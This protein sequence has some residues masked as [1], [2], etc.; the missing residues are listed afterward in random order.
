VSPERSRA[1]IAGVA[2]EFA[3]AIPDKSLLQLRADVARAAA[4]DAGIALKDVDGLIIGES[5]GISNPRYHMEFAE[6]LGLYETPLCVSVPMGGASAGYALEIARWALEQGRCRNILVLQGRKE[7]SAGPSESGQR[8]TEMMATLTM[9]YPDYELPFGPLMPSFYGAVAQRHMYEYGTTEEQLASV[10]VAIRHN[11]SLN[12][13]AVYRDPITVDDVLASPMISSP[14]HRLHCCMIND[15]AT[16]W[17]LTT[18]ERAVD[19]PHPPVYVLGSGGGQAGYFT[20]FLATMGRERGYSL[21]R[22]LGVRAAEDAFAEAGVSRDEVDLA[23]IGDSF[24]ISPLVLLEDYGFCEKGEG[25]SFV[26]DGSRIMVGGELPVNPHGGLLSCSHAAA[27]F[28]NYVEATLQLRGVCGERQV[29]DARIA[30]ASC[31]AGIISTHY[32]AVLAR[33]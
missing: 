24:A 8:Y 7:R 1:A 21:T 25:G 32:V 18:G 33:G 4:E 10:A 27:N 29:P 9:H 2:T 23:T 11:A 26:G 6:L 28:Q 20:G 12:P 31:N 16:A 15:G 3:A 5:T 13:D 17:V 14:L 19:G 22:T 30:L